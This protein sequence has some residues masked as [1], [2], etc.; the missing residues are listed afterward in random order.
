MNL[1]WKSIGFITGWS[2]PFNR[3]HNLW[4]RVILTIGIWTITREN[5][6]PNLIRIYKF[7]PCP[8]ILEAYK[9][10]HYYHFICFFNVKILILTLQLF[11]LIWHINEWKKCF[12]HRYLAI[13]Y[14]IIKIESNSNKQRERVSHDRGHMPIFSRS[15]IFMPETTIFKEGG[16]NKKKWVTC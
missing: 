4:P 13:N 5:M 1:S 11:S 12:K 16:A 2:I 10:L 15:D 14:C 3:D 9:F 7:R 6:N 8:L